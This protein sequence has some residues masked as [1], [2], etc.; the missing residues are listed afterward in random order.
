MIISVFSPAND[1]K[2]RNGGL[3]RIQNEAQ[4][5]LEHEPFRDEAQNALFKDPIHTAH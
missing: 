3:Q 4:F 5:L 1:V 2:I